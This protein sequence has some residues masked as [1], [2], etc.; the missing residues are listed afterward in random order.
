VIYSFNGGDN[1]P[2]ALLTM[3][4]AGNIYGTTVGGG[5]YGWGTVF[6]LSPSGG[7]WNYTDLYDFTGGTD[8]GHPQSQI[9]LDSKGNIYGTANVG[10]DVSACNGYGCGTVWEITP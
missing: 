10:G 1:G 2:D 5:R 4:A 9:A 7:G 8:G 3:D 6:E